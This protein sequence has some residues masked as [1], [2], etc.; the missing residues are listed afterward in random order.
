MTAAVLVL[1]AF[2]VLLTAGVLWA[3]VPLLHPSPD[4]DTGETGHAA[5]G[6]GL[7]LYS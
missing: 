7:T 3:A 1:S 4:L 2:C 5:V 6:I